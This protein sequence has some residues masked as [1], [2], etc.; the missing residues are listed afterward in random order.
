MQI[1]FYKEEI[2]KPE[3]YRRGKKNVVTVQN[4]YMFL[5]TEVELDFYVDKHMRRLAKEFIV[6]SVIENKQLENV[7]MLLYCDHS[8][9]VGV[10]LTRNF[11]DLF[12]FEVKSGKVFYNNGVDG[13]SSE[14]LYFK[15]NTKFLCPSKRNLVSNFFSLIQTKT[16]K[17]YFDKHNTKWMRDA[18]NE[19]PWLILFYCFHR[20]G[21]HII[22]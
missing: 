13:E 4:M 22:F 11:I 10:D 12:C 8:N 7:T 9:Y 2:E 21:L 19:I 20:K 1:D 17:I 3:T 5:E 6:Q 18:I 16:D 14:Y 15:K